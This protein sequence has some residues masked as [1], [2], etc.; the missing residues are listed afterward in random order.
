MRRFA[1]LLMYSA[2]AAA[3]IFV[4]LQSAHAGDPLYVAGA[5]YF[6]PATKGT[7][8]VWAQNTV[9]YYTDPGDLSPVLPHAAADTLVA[10]AFSRWT[11]IST[12][13]FM[14][15]QAGQLAED[16]DGTNV[17]LTAAGLSLPADIQPTA[18]S[19][20]VAIVYDLDG[21]VTETLLGI[22][23]SADCLNNAVY[24]GLDNFATNGNFA[25]ALVILNGMCVQDPSQLVDFEYRL[26]RV[27]GHVLG[28]GASQAN[29]NVWT[30][31]PT[32]SDVDFAGFP[33]MHAMDL[34]NCLPIT[35]C[36]PNPDQPKMD[37]RAALGRLYPVTAAYQ[38]NFPTKSL[39]SASTVRIHGTVSFPGT[40]VPGQGMQGVNIVARWIDPATLQPSRAY[41]ASAVSG[42]RYRGNIGNPITG[43]TDVAGQ[44][45]DRWGSDDPALQGFFDL[46]GLEIPNGDPSASYELTLERVDPLYSEAVGSYA[47]LQVDPSGTSPR[48]VV[49]VFQSMDSQQDI[50]MT[51]G[52]TAPTDTLDSQDFLN[53]V[54]VPGGGGWLSW[55]TTAGGTNY[56]TLT[57]QANRTLS[58]EVAT[59]DEQ[60]N[61]TQSKAQPV[62]GMW[63]LFAPP[64]TTPPAS[65]P[66]PFNTHI[67]GLTRLDAQVLI[68]TDFRI[69][70][71]DWRGDGRPDYAH[72]VRVLYA[73]TIS[74][75][76]AGA[77]GGDAL[78]IVGLG[79]QPEMAAQV[80][81]VAASVVDFGANQLVLQ[82]PALPDGVQT[83]VVS[84]PATQGFSTM[85]DVVTIG[86]GPTDT[87]QLLPVANPAI[88]VGGETLNPLQFQVV[89]TDGTP[90]V[91]ATVALSTTNGLTL[92]P[93]GGATSC[94]VFSDESGRV[95]VNVGF[96]A[97]GPGVVTGQLAP[98]S[99]ANPSTAMATLTGVSSSLDIALVGQ[100]VKL[101]QGTT[102]DVPLIARVLNG[103]SPQPGVAVNFRVAVGQGVLGAASVVTDANGNAPNTL[104]L[105]PVAADVQITACVAPL[106]N[107]C[108][109]FTASV[110]PVALLQVEAFDGTQQVVTEGQ[111]V[112]PI[113]VRVTD[114][115]SPPFPVFG[116]NVM[117]LNVLSRSGSGGPPIVVDD[118][119]S[120][121]NSDPVILGTT[122]TMVVSDGDGLAMVV[123]WATTV[124][125]GEEVS[126]LATVDSGAQVSFAMQVLAAAT[127]GTARVSGSS[128]GRRASVPNT[129]HNR[130]NL[131]GFFGLFTGMLPA[132]TA[133]D[134][135]AE[136]NVAEEPEPL[137]EATQLERDV[138][139][140]DSRKDAG[141]NPAQDVRPKAVN[142]G[143]AA[144]G[145]A[146]KTPCE[147]C[148]GSVCQEIP[149]Q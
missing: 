21:Q 89:A 59:V 52:A 138:I 49:S 112:T 125:A 142:P 25:H 120:N 17:T 81:G 72:H 86:A 105:A 53:P 124:T 147:R 148:S 104:H 127:G 62:V 29:L 114:S 22:G 110:V 7:P 79:F 83:V 28:L 51:G 15:T 118:V 57:A 26:V 8:L 55:F 44:S 12:V 63:S 35:S 38:A 73:D 47:P 65:T 58:V 71:T 19:T 6:D 117:F 123:P 116:A 54:A 78:Q 98:A 34:A 10:D 2:L 95:V 39:F 56:Y 145:E 135:A 134:A 68:A 3:W 48:V 70:I 32:P 143:S 75:V 137:K 16:V 94:S 46:A 141:E 60:G 146:R 93:C 11:N 69:G 103:L 37:D 1:R 132:W 149:L 5:S 140:Q 115:S 27:L 91:G 122:T 130:R 23:S 64:G 87:L 33:V 92:D 4:L 76:R 133:D 31:S 74:P 144:T 82:T 101:E 111:L 36:L 20:P 99:Y 41:V 24:G 61:A 67:L 45:Y 121:P 9:A 131:S 136:G 113:T 90:V 14:A 66:N 102:V 18:V 88:P 42:G 139:V 100:L 50:V 106:N 108:K 80:G 84:D 13:A 43:F 126:G 129:V 30:N 77:P 128:V 109:T 96:T 107:P 40:D 97:V 119:V 85:T